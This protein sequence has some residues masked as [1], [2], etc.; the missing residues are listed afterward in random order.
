VLTPLVARAGGEGTTRAFLLVLLSLLVHDAMD[1]LQLPGRRAPLWPL[2]FRAD[3]GMWIPSTFGGEAA[4]CLA[5]LIVAAGY[6]YWRQPIRLGGRRDWVALSAVAL[7]GTLALTASE[8]RDRRERD[9]DR[10]YVLAEGGQHAEALAACESA[11]RW[12]SSARP[13]RIDYVRAMAWWGRGEPAKAEELYLRSY[14]ADPDYIWTVADLAALH[15]EADA[16]LAERRQRAERWLIVL[17]ER[18]RDHPARPRLI[19]RVERRLAQP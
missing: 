19:A 18:F 7:I 1:I 3:V 15:A 10:A 8:L 11:D 13:G 6:R 14:A 17:S 9:L 16:P 5:P 12:P 2:P 4:V